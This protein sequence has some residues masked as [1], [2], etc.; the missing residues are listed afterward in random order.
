MSI[1]SIG[2]LNFP[3]PLSGKRSAHV[4]RFPL[5]SDEF[6]SLEMDWLQHGDR[7]T[8][9]FHKYASER[10]RTNKIRKLIKDDGDVVEETG[11][12]QELVTNF[13]INLFQSHEG[14]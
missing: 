11:A 14:N 7:N 13:Y 1:F 2:L 9:F 12:I 10:R 5:K 6:K 3:L 8:K 4:D